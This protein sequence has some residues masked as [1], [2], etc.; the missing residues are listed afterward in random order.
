[1][2]H[3][4]LVADF[5]KAR[6]NEFCLMSRKKGGKYQRKKGLGVV[7]L[8]QGGLTNITHL[9]ICLNLEGG[10]FGIVSVLTLYG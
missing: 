7:E 4:L 1:M 10:L 6:Q 5:G 2:P 3:I 8:I 9:Q